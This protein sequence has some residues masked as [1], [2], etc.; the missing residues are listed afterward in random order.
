MRYFVAKRARAWGTTKNSNAFSR[1][2]S[3]RRKPF[4]GK[5]SSQRINI[6]NR[7]T[8]RYELATI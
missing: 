6:E 5:A 8:A 7:K 4:M 3:R 2:V 1:P